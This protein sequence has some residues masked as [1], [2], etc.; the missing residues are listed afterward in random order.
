[1]ACYI[2]LKERDDLVEP[3]EFAETQVQHPPEQVPSLRCRRPS[4][5]S[6]SRRH[7]HHHRGQ[8]RNHATLRG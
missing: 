7:G 6:T 3:G 5:K 1:M 4:R 2:R 8:Y